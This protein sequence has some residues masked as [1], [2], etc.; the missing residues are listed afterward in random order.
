VRIAR[1]SDDDLAQDLDLIVSGLP[2]T[3]SRELTIRIKK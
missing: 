3:T 2:S 1:D